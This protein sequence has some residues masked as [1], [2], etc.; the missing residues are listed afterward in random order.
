[1]T[2]K[3]AGRVVLAVAGVLL[4]GALVRAQAPGSG[5]AAPGP[6]QHHS[7][8]EHPFGLG[9]ARWWNSPRMAEQLKLTDEQRKAMDGIFY[10]HR[11]KLVD[12]HANLEKA[13]LAMEPLMSADQPN[14]TA[15]SAQIDKVVAARAD[16]ERAN[17][18][19]LLAIRMKLTPDQWKQLREMRTRFMERPRGAAPQREWG[20][21]PNGQQPPAAMPPNPPAQPQPAPQQ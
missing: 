15:V 6:M 10:A 21:R 19:F 13:E 16:L 9:G 12:L 7:T 11:E 1:M 18:R 8:M 4:A 14:E 3:M 17:S 2:V 20:R 5:M